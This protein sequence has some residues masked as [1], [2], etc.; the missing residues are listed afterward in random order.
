MSMRVP[1]G[2]ENYAEPSSKALVRAVE[3]P[4]NQ[5]SSASDNTSSRKYDIPPLLRIFTSKEIVPV[6]FEYE[7]AIL[8]M[9]EHDYARVPERKEVLK[10]SSLLDEA[11][12]LYEEQQRD[13][14][15]PGAFSDLTM[16]LNTRKDLL[17]FRASLPKREDGMVTDHHREVIGLQIDLIREQQEQLHDKD[18]ELCTVRKDKEQVSSLACSSMAGGFPLT[19]FLIKRFSTKKFFLK[20]LLLIF[21]H[22]DLANYQGRE[23]R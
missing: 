1:G 18:K 15:P 3:G 2:E 20:I 7:K 14:Q 12:L 4:S 21:M 9:K 11:P 17:Q 19:Y 5:S 23:I 16:L 8:V 13:S 10:L 6:I 22:E